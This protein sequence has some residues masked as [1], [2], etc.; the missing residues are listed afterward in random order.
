MSTLE[1]RQ[2][3]FAASFGLSFEHYKK[4]ASALNSTEL[5]TCLELLKARRHRSG[6]RA[7][8]TSQINAWLNGSEHLK[9]LS[10]RQFKGAEPKWPIPYTIPT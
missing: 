3:E 1:Q 4:L 5:I 8:C 2:A 6:F 7:S 9:P 10:P